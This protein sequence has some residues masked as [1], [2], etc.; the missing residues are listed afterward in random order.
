MDFIKHNTWCTIDYG[1]NTYRMKLRTDS[2]IYSCIKC[3]KLNY[4]F[5]GQTWKNL[6]T[7]NFNDI[8][9]RELKYSKEYFIDLF[10]KLLKRQKKLDSKESIDYI[11][12]IQ[13]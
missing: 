3:Q 2:N 11:N 8:I 7:Y 12:H 6:D 5:F 1:G 13:L 9:Y 4:T 10:L